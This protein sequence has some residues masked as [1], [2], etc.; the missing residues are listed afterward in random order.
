MTDA[1]FKWAFE[2]VHEIEKGLVDNP[3]DPGGITNHGI[4]L[5]FATD[6]GDLDND[7]RLDLDID[8]S[9]QVDAGDIRKMTKE[10]AATIYEA[11]FWKLL[12][13]PELQ[14]EGLALQVFDAGVNQGRGAAVGLL[15]ASLGVVVDGKLGP[16]TMAAANAVANRLD[17]IVEYSARRAFRYAT[18]KNFD[19]FGLGWMR[20]NARI[21]EQ[22]IAI[23][24]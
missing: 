3:R 14:S 23:E 13:C 20:R 11:Y 12:R 18:T 7:G 19:A 16:K 22:A 2:V 10:D 1:A 24:R 5:R 9:G 17:L 21:L 6:V 8:G 4:S 15:Q